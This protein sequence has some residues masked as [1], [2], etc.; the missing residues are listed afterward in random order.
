MA[1]TTHLPRISDELGVAVYSPEDFTEAVTAVR[2]LTPAV[3]S[4]IRRLDF[5]P[6]R[7]VFLNSIQIYV[8]SELISPEHCVEQVRLLRELLVTIYHE[9]HDAG[10]A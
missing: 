1:A 9:I 8:I 6:I 5:S 2:L 3:F 4:L 7:L 10:A